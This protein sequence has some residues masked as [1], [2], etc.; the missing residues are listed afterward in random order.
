MCRAQGTAVASDF[1]SVQVRRESTR[2]CTTGHVSST[3][4]CR[5]AHR[6]SRVLLLLQSSILRGQLF[7]FLLLQIQVCR[8]FIQLI[9]K[10]AVLRRLI[11]LC[12]RMP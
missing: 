2:R 5:G 11:V 6:S 4:A 8:N 12:L 3:C 7:H 10:F 1:Y 9:L